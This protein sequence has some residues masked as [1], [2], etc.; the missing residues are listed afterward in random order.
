[1]GMQWLYSALLLGIL[2]LTL[3]NP[4]IAPIV[5]F[6]GA[7]IGLLIS[8]YAFVNVLSQRYQ[9]GRSKKRLEQELISLQNELG[10]SWIS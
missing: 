1:M 10:E 2:F 3:S 6:V 4:S 5:A 8:A 7:S 9:L